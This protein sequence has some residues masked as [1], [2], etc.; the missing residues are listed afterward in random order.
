M[1]LGL[2]PLIL[3]ACLPP[4]SPR[5]PC[6]ALCEA[7]TNRFEACLDEREETWESAGY[8]SAADYQDSCHTW[9]WELGILTRSTEAPDEA[10][11]KLDTFCA[12][13]QALVEEE[14]TSCEAF[15]ALDW[16]TE[17]WLR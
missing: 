13:Q 9:A 7:T 14:S 3:S 1:R 15:L 2:L 8:S 6:E 17:P 12:D 11:A 16:E 4:G 10:T 5:A